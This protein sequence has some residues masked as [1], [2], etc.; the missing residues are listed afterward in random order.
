[1]SKAK[2]NYRDLAALPLESVV[3]VA[4]GASAAD[5]AKPDGADKLV[6]FATVGDWMIRD[7]AS[8]TMPTAYEPGAAVTNG[9]AAHSIPE[10]QGFVFTVDDDVTVKGNGATAALTY[11]WM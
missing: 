11:Y 10:S 8:A 5:L 3:N 7:G 1:M 2:N 4:Y 9:T 6:V